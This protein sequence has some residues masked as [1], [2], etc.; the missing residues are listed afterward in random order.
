VKRL[1][2][3]PTDISQP[4]WDATR[5]QRFLLQWCQSCR[6]PIFYPREVC[7]RCLGTALEWKPASGLGQVHAVSV[8]HPATGDDAYAVALIDLAEG[9]RVMSNVIDCAPDDIAVGMPVTLAW[10]PLSDGRNLP[11]FRPAQ[12]ATTP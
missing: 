11:Q 3:P 7:P 5:D 8:Q 4:F 12:G 1:E 9:V 2:P 10:E 6:Q